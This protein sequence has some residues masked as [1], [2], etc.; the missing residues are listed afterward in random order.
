MLGKR[1][2]AFSLSFGMFALV[3]RADAG[4]WQEMH[5]T[6]DD[7]R[8]EILPDGQAD[9]QHHLRYRVVAGHFK[10]FDLAGIDPRAVVVAE[11]TFTPD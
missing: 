1:W 8:I 6:S 2:V 3:A 9:V 10:T 5:E 7:V 11:A 4:G